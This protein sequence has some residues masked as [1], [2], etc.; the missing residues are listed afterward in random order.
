MYHHSTH[1]PNRRSTSLTQVSGP[2][3]RA[4]DTCYVP[5]Q[6]SPSQS[7]FHV[8]NPPFRP[9]RRA[10]DTCHVPP[11][12]SP[13][14]PTTATATTIDDCDNR[15]RHPG[16]TSLTGPPHLDHVERRFTHPLQPTRWWE[17]H[18]PPCSLSI[19]PRTNEP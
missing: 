17:S 14:Q 1:H 15:Q 8:T 9:P 13:S 18:P 6:H 19:T 10:Q 12:H 5:P 2:Q 4:Q 3:H 16:S 11:Q 7:T